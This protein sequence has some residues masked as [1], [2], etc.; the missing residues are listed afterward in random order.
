M[1]LLD[2]T[3][4]GDEVRRLIVGATEAHLSGKHLS[5]LPA[6]RRDYSKTVTDPAVLRRYADRFTADLTLRTQRFK[7]AA[8]QHV[9]VEFKRE[10]V[11]LSHSSRFL[12]ASRDGKKWYAAVLE[13][14]KL[15]DL[16]VEMV[17]NPD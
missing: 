11:R 2:D 17:T 12:A 10:K 15:F 4:T 16:A 14:D 3:L 9:G 1:P 6:E 8:L 13:D 5:K 7:P